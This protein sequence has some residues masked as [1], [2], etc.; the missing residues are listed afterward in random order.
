V[1]LEELISFCTNPGTPSRLA[2]SPTKKAALQQGRFFSACRKYTGVAGIFRTR[3]ARAFDDSGTAKTSFMRRQW[4]H[5]GCPSLRYAL[6]SRWQAFPL[7][8][9]RDFTAAPTV[10]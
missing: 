2:A 5:G 6:H 10:A 7:A 1:E 9:F 8:C 3:P 4:R